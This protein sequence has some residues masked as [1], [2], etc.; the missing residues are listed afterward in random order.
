MLTLIEIK[1]WKIVYEIAVKVM[2]EMHL[3]FQE[4]QGLY[5]EVKVYTNNN[6]IKLAK[7]SSA[8]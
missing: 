5:V 8:V 1:V 4:K 6:L 3:I 7:T 2:F